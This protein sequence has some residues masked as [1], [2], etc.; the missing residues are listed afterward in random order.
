[1][2]QDL[3]FVSI[4]WQERLNHWQAIQKEVLRR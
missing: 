1:M 3:S 4:T 2:N